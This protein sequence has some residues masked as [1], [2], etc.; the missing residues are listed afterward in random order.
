MSVTLLP[1]DPREA[2]FLQFTVDGYRSLSPAQKKRALALIEGET[3]QVRSETTRRH[4]RTISLLTLE[5]VK[6]GTM[7]R[8][9]AVQLY[10]YDAQL[11]YCK[12]ASFE[13]SKNGVAKFEASVFYN[14]A[15]PLALTCLSL[16]PDIDRLYFKLMPAYARVLQGLRQSPY[17]SLA[18]LRGLAAQSPDEL[19]LALRLTQ[20]SAKL[21]SPAE[22]RAQLLQLRDHFGLQNDALLR[23]WMRE[24]DHLIEL[25]RAK[26]EK[27]R[28]ESLIMHA[29]NCFDSGLYAYALQGY[30]LAL[31]EGTADV[32]LMK[33]IDEI[34]DLCNCHFVN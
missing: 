11:A 30:L 23:G 34:Y 14:A 2:I 7:P 28:H 26:Y 1:F 12:V 3:L 22:H 24:T 10:G 33:R 13:V 5:G 19:Y 18:R 17:E 29:S 16:Y 15:T 4:V 25:K 20:L 31:Q 9:F 27:A 32:S 6:I 21:V 8:M